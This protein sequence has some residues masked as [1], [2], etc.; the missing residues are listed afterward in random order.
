ML[1]QERREKEAGVSRLSLSSD[2][3]VA[4]DL[5]SMRKVP[6]WNDDHGASYGPSTS[7][8]YDAQ[9]TRHSLS[10]LGSR[11]FLCLGS[12]QGHLRKERGIIR[13]LKIDKQ[14]WKFRKLSLERAELGGQVIWTVSGHGIIQGTH[15][16]HSLPCGSPVCC[17][18]CFAAEIEARSQW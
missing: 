13:T 16:L 1:Q 11:L 7:L 17:W 6:A 2:R 3:E 15:L 9:R 4:V 18:H 14:V 10:H 12:F 8:N 5:W